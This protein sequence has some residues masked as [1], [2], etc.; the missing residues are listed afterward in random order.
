M[1]LA[2]G[3][4]ESGY[5]E[6]ISKNFSA[7]KGTINVHRSKALMQDLSAGQDKTQWSQGTIRLF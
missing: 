2:G 3:E 7:L 1:E 6:R 4:G 5:L